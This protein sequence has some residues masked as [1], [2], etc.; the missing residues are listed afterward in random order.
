MGT[1]NAQSYTVNSDIEITATVAAGT[2]S[3]KVSVDR[4]GRN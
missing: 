3:G 2:H 4:A 1:R